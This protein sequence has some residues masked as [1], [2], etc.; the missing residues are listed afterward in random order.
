MDATLHTA[1]EAWLRE[2]DPD[3][4]LVRAW[5]LKGGVSSGMIA[6]E[7]S[8]PGEP[9]V[10]F[11][12]RQ[13]SGHVAGGA[14][15]A[16]RREHQ[17]LTWLDDRGAIVPQP[18]DLD[19][20][21]ARFGKPSLVI[22]FVEGDMRFDPRDRI[23]YA[24]AFAGG[25]Y[26][27]HWHGRAQNGLDF[28]P[29]IASVAAVMLERVRR[30]APAN[31]DEAGWLDLLM[32]R[33]PIEER[34]ESTLLHGDYWPGNVLW[35]DGCISAIVD[36]EES[37]WGDPLSDLALSR[38]D[39]LWMLDEAAVD[40]FTAHYAD[41]TDVDLTRLPEWDLWASLRPYGCLDL[42]S[43][44]WPSFGRPDINAQTMAIKLKAFAQRAVERLA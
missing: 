1:L 40:A 18:Y 16:A 26:H 35:G 7:A 39:L 4:R 43:S 25:L 37:A 21:G 15:V 3:A 6:F 42:W 9:D 10:R 41:L 12:L 44:G 5:P 8:R 13:P 22:E 24:R 2:R 34:N 14:P 28:L 17:L 30:E 38:L 33:F 27:V 31:S 32:P 11:V 29:E 20:F 36:W 19:V 23:A